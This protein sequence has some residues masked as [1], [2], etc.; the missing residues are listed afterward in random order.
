MK[1]YIKTLQ[2]YH[3]EKVHPLKNEVLVLPVNELFGRIDAEKHLRNRFYSIFIFKEANGSVIID[4]QIYELKKD[5]LLFMNYNQVYYFNPS[6]EPEGY[7]VL[8]TKSFYNY[9][10]TGNK[11]IRS[12]TRMAE[13]P[14]VIDLHAS[15]VAEF[16]QQFYIIRK[17]YGGNRMF[18]KEIICMQLKIFILRY[19]RASKMKESSLPADHKKETVAN[20]SEL[21]NEFYKDLKTTAPYAEKLNLSPNYLNALIKQ[22]LALSAG[23]FIKN[24]VILEAERL[25]LHTNL[26]VTEISYEL[27]FTDNSH[28][29]KYF[30]SAT[31]KSP[32]I[33]RTENKI[34]KS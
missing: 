20:F 9:V 4:D 21:V 28:F 14:Q 34:Q 1:Q 2:M 29:G 3:L 25:L 7:V 22:H 33:Y 10:Y 30:K 17:E 26:S 13:M 19:V 27:G 23:Q 8:F 32:K 15:S 16:W 11:L 18:T 12:D 5:R 6:S 31:N 24:R